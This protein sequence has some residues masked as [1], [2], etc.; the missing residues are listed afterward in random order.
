MERKA[1]GGGI[2]RMGGSPRSALLAAA[3]A[4]AAGACSLQEVTTAPG[5]DVLVVEAVLRTDRQEQYVLLHR[6]LQGATDPGEPGA[7]VVIRRVGGDSVR[8]REAP[9]SACTSVDPIYPQEDSLVVRATCYTTAG[10]LPTPPGQAA[11]QLVE[12]GAVY[13][14]TVRTLRGEVA[15]GRTRVP[16]AFALLGALAPQGGASSCILPPDTSFAVTWSRADSTWTYLARMS[17]TGLPE[18]L[19][20]R[21]KVGDIPDPYELLGLA[22]S[23]SDT[24]IVLPK[25]FGVFDRF[26][27]DSDLLVLLQGGFP[28]GVDA[29]L[30][31]AAADRNYLNGVRG[32]RFNPSG[33]AR[34][35]SVVGDGIGV[36]G[37]LNALSASIAVRSLRGGQHSCLG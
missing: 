2:V 25:E 29:E 6:T 3:L 31:V 18:A 33:Q 15:R 32:G 35:S 14:L 13:E 37:S 28:P 22:V 30:I 17:V 1:R 26:T 5:A 12:P 9:A 16:G 36:F 11:P 24:T 4:L 34:I 23:E 21:G 19:R 8:L 27:G 20:A 10:T 7:A